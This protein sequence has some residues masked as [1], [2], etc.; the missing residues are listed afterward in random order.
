MIG[1]S[2]KEI[3]NATLGHPSEQCD[4]INRIGKIAF[5]GRIGRIIP[6]KREDTPA[7][8]QVYSPGSGSPER[9]TQPWG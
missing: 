6:A 4:K 1:W 3:S 7:G 2:D 9:A 8:W 5:G